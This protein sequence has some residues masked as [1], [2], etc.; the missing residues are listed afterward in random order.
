[1]AKLAY[2]GMISQLGFTALAFLWLYSGYRA[3]RH[4]RDGQ[5]EQHRQ[6]MIRNY[7]LTFAG[8]MLRVWVPISGSMG[9][10]FVMAYRA[11]A[12]LCW[13]PN[14]LVAQWIISRTRPGRRR[15][16]IDLVSGQ[17]SRS[18]TV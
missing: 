13:V 4:I 11:I 6:W 10:D 8:V 17:A 18:E 15:L 16:G 2:G 1:M 7:A 14:L 3:Y 5:L 9:I 12:W